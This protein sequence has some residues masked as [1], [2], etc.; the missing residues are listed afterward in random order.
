MGPGLKFSDCSWVLLLP[1]S[2]YS[3]EASH[4]PEILHLSHSN[5]VETEGHIVIW[6]W[7]D[8]KAHK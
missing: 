8:S 4:L 3:R 2:V 1:T 5:Q 7:V 6:K